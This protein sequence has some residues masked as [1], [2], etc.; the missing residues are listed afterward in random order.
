V[1]VWKS[2]GV[3]TIQDVMKREITLGGT[4]PGSSIVIF[5][6]AM[7]NVLGTKF[8]IVTGY[9]S[10]EDVSLAMQRGEVQSRVLAYSSI[11]TTHPEWIKDNKIDFL[12]QVGFKRDPDLPGVPL[13][14]ELA[15]TDEDRAVLRLISSPIPLG[16]AYLAPP[17]TPSGR[18][19]LLR[20]AFDETMTDKAF[21]A[22]ADRRHLDLDPIDA[23]EVEKIV[24]ETIDTPRIIVGKAKAAMGLPGASK[25]RH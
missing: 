9:K 11:L 5:P 20:K 22:E 1:F 3:K 8:K 24:A 25:P 12:V 15:K 14:T 13:M 18:V 7:N 6:T 16:Q 4:A 17:G 21:R 19:S 23:A 2:T 10:S